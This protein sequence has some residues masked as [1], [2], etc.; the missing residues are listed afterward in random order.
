MYCV[1]ARRL[2]IRAGAKCGRVASNGASGRRARLVNREIDMKKEIKDALEKA[3]A[4]FDTHVAE[5]QRAHERQVVE[6]N[7]FEAEWRRVRD[8]VVV[9]ALR[10]V[11]DLLV[12]AGWKCEVRI[13]DKNHEVR[14]LTYRD[15]MV[16]ATG[17]PY[18]G[19]EPG[20]NLVKVRITTQ[21]YSGEEGQ[22]P[23]GQINEDFVQTCA[24]RF[25]ERLASERQSEQ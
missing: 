13:S 12:R 15:K 2:G 5:R 1:S 6:Q 17:R 20:A 21:G 4:D 24:S 19:F 14:L 7:K 3:I 22:F 16:T 8:D 18:V 23:L 11:R 25:F 9:P 10:Q